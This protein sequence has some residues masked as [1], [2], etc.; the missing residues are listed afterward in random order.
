MSRILYL[1][2]HFSTPEGATAT[3]AFA[4][5]RALAA[6]GHRVTLAC[7]G[8]AGART[9]LDGYFELVV[10]GD[11]LPARKPDPLPMRHVAARFELACA[12]IVAIGDSANDALAAR[13]AGMR[14]LAVPYGYNEGRPVESLDVDAVVDTLLD[15]ARWIGC[16]PQ[17]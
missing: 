2:Q 7:G 8:Y 9:G 5:A 15:A 11:T 10:S 1:H 17:P 13:A 3:R 16:P 4:Q 6:A 14:V 12:E